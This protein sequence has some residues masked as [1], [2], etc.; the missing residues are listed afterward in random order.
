M[1]RRR[2]RE[3]RGGE[4]RRERTGGGG[5]GENIRRRREREPR[6]GENESQ[7]EERDGGREQEEEEEERKERCSGTLHWSGCGKSSCGSRIHFNTNQV[8]LI[9]KTV[10][11]STWPA[12][13]RDSTGT[14]D[15]DELIKP[16]LPD[17]A[18]RETITS[19]TVA[20]EQNATLN[21]IWEM[22]KWRT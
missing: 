18:E 3:P 12:L 10:N 15:R 20:R 6:G 19:S 11:Q 9:N 1:R 5:R 7:E 13:Q 16:N 4:R 17:P 8:W 14:S 2:E 21:P 22:R